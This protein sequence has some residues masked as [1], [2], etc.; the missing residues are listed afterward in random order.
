MTSAGGLRFL[1]NPR[2][3]GQGGLV[4]C[5]QMQIRIGDSDQVDLAE[6]GEVGACRIEPAPTDV[7]KGWRNLDEMGRG[8]RA[9][10]LDAP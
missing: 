8:D 7:R 1:V 6:A 10:E 2:D 3:G 5:A 9:Q 4:P